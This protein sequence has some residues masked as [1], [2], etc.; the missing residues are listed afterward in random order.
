M[1]IKIRIKYIILVI[2]CPDLKLYFV[3]YITKI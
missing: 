1:H 2:G 3:I